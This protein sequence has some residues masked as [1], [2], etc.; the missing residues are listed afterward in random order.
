MSRRSLPACV[1]VDTMLKRASP[2][3]GRIIARV[4]QMLDIV[5]P[6]LTTTSSA[7]VIDVFFYS[8]AK[9]PKQ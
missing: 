3:A 8:G 7:V 5:S 1:G 6:I 4:S 9:K 2:L